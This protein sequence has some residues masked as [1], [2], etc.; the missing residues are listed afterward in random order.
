MAGY[1]NCFAVECLKVGRVIVL[2]LLFLLLDTSTAAGVQII[3]VKDG[4]ELKTREPQHF[5]YLNPVKPGWRETWTRIQ[6]RVWSSKDLKVTV[7]NDEQEL[8]ELEHFSFWTLVQYFIREQTNETF[9][10]IN[11]FAPKTCFRVDPSNSQTLY[12]VKP[13]RKFDIYLI[14]VFLVGVLLF[15]FADILS[16][17]QMF[18]Y[19]AGMSTGMVASLLIFI[20]I[21]ARFLPKK[22]PF[23]VLVVG[24]WSFSMYIIQLVCRNLQL[25]L[26]DH[27]PLAIGYT[28]VVG[29]ISFAVCY[30]HG[31]LVDKRS[32]NIL[33][34]TLQLFGLLLIYA[35]IQVQQVALAIMVAAFCAK[36]LE[37]PLNMAFSIY[38]KMNRRMGWNLEPRRLLTNE[39]Y[40]NQ[41]EVETSRA[42]DELRKY[43]SSPDYNHWKTVSRLQSPKRF[44]DFV[45]GVPHLLPNEVS[46]HEQEYGF[47]GSFLEDELFATDE[48]DDDDDDEVEGECQK[49]DK[50]I[51]LFARKEVW[52]QDQGDRKL[53]F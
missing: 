22:S 3:E 50:E 7:V 17:S 43:C 30:R 6:V 9:V 37:Y 4:Q 26:K 52:P 8:Q 35:G 45:E 16:R 28:A 29:F 14:L 32:I 19:S 25:I 38:H 31:P 1:M 42:L 15:F 46:V 21:I 12:T 47:E 13:I 2:I 40:Q 23:Y 27:W 51:Q 36:N 11:L 5:C 18:Y 49:D 10:H 53:P 20:F 44:A 48:E 39:E 41:A 33:S 24:G 34:W